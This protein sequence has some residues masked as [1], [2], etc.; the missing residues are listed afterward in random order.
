MKYLTAALAALAGVAPTL[1]SA[2]PP[3]TTTLVQG[4]SVLYATHGSSGTSDIL[5]YSGPLTLRGVRIDWVGFA[6][7]GYNFG[8]PSDDDEHFTV[9]YAGTANFFAY[10]WDAPNFGGAAALRDIKGSSDCTSTECSLG[11]EGGGTYFEQKA[12]LSQWVGNGTITFDSN[13][14]LAFP[15]WGFDEFYTGAYGSVTYTLS[16]PDVPEPASWAMM[17]AGFAAMGGA[18]RHRRHLAVSAVSRESQ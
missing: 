2:S 18:L 12:G 11:G 4:F 15:G 8:Q 3:T 6:Y 13:S 16:P 17:L 7:T 1:A 14:Q 10:S 5:Q 9:P